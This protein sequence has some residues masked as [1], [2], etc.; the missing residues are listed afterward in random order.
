MF[1]NDLLHKLF[2]AKDRANSK[3]IL[4]RCAKLMY[5]LEFTIGPRKW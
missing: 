5:Y 4:H 3:N 2:I 1:T